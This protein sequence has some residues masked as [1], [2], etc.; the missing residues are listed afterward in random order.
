MESTSEERIFT[1]G[2]GKYLPEPPV[3]ED[4]T[5]TNMHVQ[6]L[7]REFRKTGPDVDMFSVDQK[8]ALTFSYRRK[9]VVNEKISVADLTETFPWLKL[10]CEVNCSCQI[11]WFFK[12]ASSLAQK[13]NYINSKLFITD[14]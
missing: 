6:A 2:L 10:R 5:S 7:K 1:W 11:M 12:M 8:M 13:C 4:E 3:S 14:T 9:L